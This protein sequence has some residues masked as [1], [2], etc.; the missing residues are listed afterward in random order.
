MKLP[1]GLILQ[2][3]AVI[4]PAN[5]KG[6]TVTLPITY[7]TVY[8][9]FVTP[10]GNT[11][12]TTFQATVEARYTTLNSFVVHMGNSEVTNSYLQGVIPWMT[13]GF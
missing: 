8:Q 9:P 5:A 13:I 1:N 11:V 4:V 10:S 3:G 6:A 7:T 2:W 12:D